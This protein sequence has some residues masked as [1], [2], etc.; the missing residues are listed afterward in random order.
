MDDVVF[1]ALEEKEFSTIL[2]CLAYKIIIKVLDEKTVVS[3][4]QTLQDCVYEEI[5]NKQATSELTPLRLV[6]A[7]RY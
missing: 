3:L 2:L 5:S 4:S 6:Y 1:E 7:R